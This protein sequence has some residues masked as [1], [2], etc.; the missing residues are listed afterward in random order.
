MWTVKYISFGKQP[1]AARPQG[2]GLA[3]RWFWSKRHESVTRGE[4]GSQIF[5]NPQRVILTF[6]NSE[7][8]IFPMNLV[9]LAEDFQNQIFFISQEKIIPNFELIFFLT[10]THV[11]LRWDWTYVP[12][13]HY[14]RGEHKGN[15]EGCRIQYKTIQEGKQTTS[16]KSQ[17]YIG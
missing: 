6:L 15:Q 5:S 16:E 14:Y 13:S 8:W 9:A 4:G 12:T 7:F 2:S 11:L 17:V 10:L 1:V 3:L